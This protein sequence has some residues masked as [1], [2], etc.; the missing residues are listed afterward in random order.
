MI[1]YGATLVTGLTNGFTYAA[2]GVTFGL[3]FFVTGRFHFAYGLFYGL[4]G[5]LAAWGV[6]VQGWGL[7]PAVLIGV[8]AAILGGV[9]CEV[10]V[11]RAFDRRAPGLSLLGIFIASLGLTVAGEATMFLA[12]DDAPS[13]YLD[14]VDSRVFMLGDIAVPAIKLATASF[15]LVV[16]VALWF[17]LAHTSFGRK[18]RAVEANPVLARTFGINVTR[19]SIAVFAIGSG[20]AGMLGIF[21]SSTY[22]ASPTMGQ[23]TIIYAFVVAFLGRGKNP[24]ANLLI[25]LALGVFEALIGQW[26]GVV[27]RN[28]VVFLVLF[29]FIAAMPY[30]SRLRGLLVPRRTVAA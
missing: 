22:A 27:S 5:V 16:L 26:F 3:I 17:T 1:E 19:V 12:F 29:A 9:L 28:L 2:L 30:A 20:V 6:E 23:A 13:Y 24:L 8:G 21:Q 4:A 14:L 11:Y 10:V 7:L 18:M 25:G 15:C